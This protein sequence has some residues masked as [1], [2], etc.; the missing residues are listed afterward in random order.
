M[1]TAGIPA[2]RVAANQPVVTF[3]A[4]SEISMNDPGQPLELNLRTRLRFERGALRHLGRLAQELGARRVLVVTDRGVAAAG[5]LE[6]AQ[7]SL[8]GAGLAV[9]GFA[10]VPEN[11]TTEDVD[12][13]VVA[14][15]AH[16]TDCLVGLGGGSALDTAKGANFLL[17]QGGQMRDFWGVGKATRPMLPFIAIPTTAGTGSEVQ[18]AALIA[19]AATH[20]K[21]ACL[22]PKAAARIA[23]LDPELTLTQP[24]RVTA[25]TGL[26][27]LAHAVEAAVT[28][29]RNW[30]SDWFAREAF[31]RLWPAFPRVLAAPDD[32]A[33]RGEMLLGAAFAG[34]AIE[35]SML[36]AAHALANPLTAHCGVVHGHAVGLLLPAVVCFNAEEEGAARVY[37]DLA[38]V[39]GRR[40][41]ESLA[42]ALRERLALT[43]LA[44]RLRD[45]GVPADKLPELAEEAARQWTAK[46]NPR[47]VTTADLRQLYELAW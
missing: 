6:R 7:A 28:K 38:E 2:R 45:C 36:G 25:G 14:A 41:G 13:C 30:I 3:P 15:R 29:E 16:G 40:A 32:V 17:T 42:D 5:H 43:G 8:A 37:A 23:L 46:F 19:D 21:M 31:R 34:W 39:A 11:P 4:V 24:P 1:R 12:A 18:C 47:P 20:Q 35:H 44:V 10:A 27:A 9:A 22:D 26:D 33:A